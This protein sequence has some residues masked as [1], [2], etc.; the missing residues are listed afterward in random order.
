MKD[1]DILH[2]VGDSVGAA[3]ELNL[4]H[5][6]VYFQQVA[7]ATDFARQ[8]G[9]TLRTLPPEQ[10]PPWVGALS[11]S[12]ING[13]HTPDQ[14]A[15]LLNDFANADRAV[16]TNAQVLSEGIDLPAVDA[17]VFASRTESVRRS[18]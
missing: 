2:D 4:K 3:A 11:I 5:V 14:R 18:R 8:F 10:R 1:E 7:G 6:I 13:N 16:S 17:I 15:T 12:S 9:H